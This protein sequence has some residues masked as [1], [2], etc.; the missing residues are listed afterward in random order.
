MES[1]T[2]GYVTLEETKKW[3]SERY[4]FEETEEW[5]SKLSKAL[6]RAFD[7]I[8]Q[9]PVRHKGEGKI[10]PRKHEKEVPFFIKM[11]QMLEAYSIAN[12]EETE[13]IQMLKGVTSRSIG[14]MSVS[15]DRTKKI[16]NNNFCNVEAAQILKRYERKTF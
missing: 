15:Y 1:T 3:L 5:N 9:V 8:E 13:Q 4:D 6:W 10:F 11:A 16:G 2:I 14:D 12:D 7:K